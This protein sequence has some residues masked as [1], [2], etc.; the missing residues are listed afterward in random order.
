MPSIST[1]FA[2]LTLHIEVAWVYIPKLPENAGIC[3][4]SGL[5]ISIQDIFTST[6]ILFKQHMAMSLS[7]LANIN[8][9][10]RYSLLVEIKILPFCTVSTNLTPK[11]N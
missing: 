7:N 3:T 10:R 4:F 6:A 1:Q 11:K 8:Y 9:L 5:G 2:L